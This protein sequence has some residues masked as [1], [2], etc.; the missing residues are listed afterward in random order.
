ML[1]EHQKHE[2]SSIVSQNFCTNKNIAN[3]WST[4]NW[5]NFFQ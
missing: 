1:C 5:S 2:I 4:F 3:N